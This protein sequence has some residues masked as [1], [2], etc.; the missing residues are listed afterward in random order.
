MVTAKDINLSYGSKTLWNKPLTFQIKS[1]DRIAI[2]RRNGSGKT[3]LLKLITGVL[4]PTA[5]VLSKTDFKYVFLD[6]DYSIINRKYTVF[7]QVENDQELWRNSACGI[8]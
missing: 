6:R 5:G 8:A 7:Q 4:E 2:K 1:G 3:S